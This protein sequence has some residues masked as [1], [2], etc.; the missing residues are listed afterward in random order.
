MV[1]HLNTTKHEA[2]IYRTHTL[3]T[4]ICKGMF[5]IRINENDKSKSNKELC[6]RLGQLA[7]LSVS[8]IILIRLQIIFIT[9]LRVEIKTIGEL[10]RAI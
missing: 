1:D 8:K 9:L 2:E 7:N 4:Q 10:L 6:F 3:I 5:R